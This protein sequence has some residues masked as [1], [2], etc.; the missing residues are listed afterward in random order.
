MRIK[1]KKIISFG[2]VISC[3]MQGMVTYAADNVNRDAEN[4]QTVSDEND[5]RLAEDLNESNIVLAEEREKAVFESKVAVTS[6]NS[7]SISRVKEI[8]DFSGN[9]YSVIECAPT[10]YYIY[11]NESGNFVEYSAESNSPYLNV[12]GKIY[13]GGPTFYY[14]E[15]EGKY[16]HTIT[17]EEFLISDKSGLAEMSTTL[18]TTLNAHKDVAV[19]DVVEGKAEINSLASTRATSYTYV[20]DYNIIKQLTSNCGYYSEGNGCC[21]YVAANIILY[22]WQRRQPNNYYIPSTWYNSSGLVGSSL[23]ENLV[24]I[25]KSLGYGTDSYPNTISDVLQRYCSDRNISASVGYWFTNINASSEISNNRPTI[26]FGNFY[27][28][29][30][31]KNINHAVVIYGYDND[32]GQYVSHFGYNNYSHVTLSGIVGGNTYFRP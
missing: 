1:V 32:S 11:H 17:D 15:N 4:E 26:L 23:T 13:Y 8:E 18:D 7:V 30:H 5:V 27:S 2:L 21:G 31:G 3:L 24:E 14:V 20:T 25:G 6:G 28:A 16:C 22:Y 29:S 19:L 12:S 9:K 10:G